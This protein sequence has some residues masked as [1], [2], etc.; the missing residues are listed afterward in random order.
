MASADRFD[1]VT[2]E[3]KERILGVFKGLQATGFKGIEWRS[4]LPRGERFVKVSLARSGGLA[5]SQSYSDR[6][7][8]IRP[9]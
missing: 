9:I 6:I 8:L 5:G 2:E 1:S 3:T 4:E 7:A